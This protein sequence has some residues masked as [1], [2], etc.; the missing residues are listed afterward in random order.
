MESSTY[1]PKF[2][3]DES[4]LT[5]LQKDEII[6]RA[7][8]LITITEKTFMKDLQ[9]P[10][11]LPRLLDPA[12]SA[13][14][15]VNG[16][17]LSIL[18]VYLIQILEEITGI[19]LEIL[20]GLKSEHLLELENSINSLVDIARETLLKPVYVDRKTWLTS[21]INVSELL[22][23]SYGYDSFRSAPRDH[24]TKTMLMGKAAEVLD[25][26]YSPDH[27][28]IR[29]LL[30]MLTDEELLCIHTPVRSELTKLA[31]YRVMEQDIPV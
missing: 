12:Y 5:E 18:K 19:R 1:E 27:E 3:V 15:D 23:V 26:A 30:D 2:N 16:D 14:C 22:V 13:A 31:R 7:R 21:C 6:K 25:L 9:D 11:V 29:S 17:K 24:V 28:P 20:L 8:N 10:S 4:D